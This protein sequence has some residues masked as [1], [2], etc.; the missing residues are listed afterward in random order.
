[1]VRQSS[2]TKRP[3]ASA[4]GAHLGP[5]AVVR[6]AQRALLGAQR[7]AGHGRGLVRRFLRLAV[8]VQRLRGRAA[9]RL[10][11]G[12]GQRGRGRSGGGRDGAPPVRTGRRAREALLQQR[13]RRPGPTARQALARVA[14]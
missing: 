10:P 3:C 14:S 2:A 7:H 5:G 11:G 6:A 9:R 12:R 8:S 1:M 4:A 13:G